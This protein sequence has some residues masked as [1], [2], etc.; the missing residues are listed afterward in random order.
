MAYIENSKPMKRMPTAII[1]LILLGMA[2]VFGAQAVRTRAGVRP[3][4]PQLDHVVIG[5]FPSWNRA[6]FDHTMIAYDSL[7][8]IAV[9]FAM[10]DAEGN[11]VLP[12][13]FVYP[14]LNQTAHLHGVKV[15]MSLGGWGNC[16]GFSPMVA[17]PVKRAKFIGQVAD[18]CRDYD[19][20]GVD[21]DWEF[22]ETSAERANFTLLIKGLAAALKA[23]TPPRLLTMAASSGDYYG[24]WIE[25]ETLHPYFDFVGFMT[26]DFH[27]PW[28]DHSGHNAPLFSCDGDECGSMNDTFLYARSRGIPLGKL[29]LGVPFYGRSFDTGYLY[30]RFRDSRYYPFYEVMTFRAAG[31]PSLWDR[32]AKV[33]YLRKPG[34]GE[35]ISYDDVSSV[36]RKCL[37]IKEKGS[38]GLIIWEISLDRWQ[39]RS[40]LIEVIRNSFL[41]K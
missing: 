12:Q 32:C 3:P 15:L 36:W 26:Y 37:Y 20:D 19:Y 24:R 13:D 35:I 1:L 16:A 4:L 28:T 14:A 38:A 2:C 40:V 7:T 30:D 39:G 17:D 21:I 18:F 22:P 25:F 8:H 5:Y 23:M 31:W 11:L 33:P 41:K 27:G 6:A 10:P 9:S 29:L 34:G